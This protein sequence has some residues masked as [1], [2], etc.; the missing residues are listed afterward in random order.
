MSCGERTRAYGNRMDNVW[1]LR[2]AFA[3]ARGYRDAQDA[4]CARAEAGLW[5]EAAAQVYPEDY[6]WESLVDVLRGRV[7][8][9]SA[10]SRRMCT[11]TQGALGLRCL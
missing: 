7:K 6:R 4:L 3:M 2:A 8:V 9:G 1:A 10:R 5:D 11:R